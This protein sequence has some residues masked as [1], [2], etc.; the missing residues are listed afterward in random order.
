MLLQL[1]AEGVRLSPAQR[2]LF[3]TLKAK[4]KILLQENKA[5]LAGTGRY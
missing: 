5:S 1:K 3:R 2:V 4:V